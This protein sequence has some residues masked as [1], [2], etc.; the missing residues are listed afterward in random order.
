MKKM[1]FALVKVGSGNLSALLLGAISMKVLAVVTGPSGIGL[2]SL[3]KNLQQTLS[4]IGSL[5]GHNVIV[6][7]IPGQQKLHQERF[8]TTVFWISIGGALLTS[9]AAII[10]AEALSM[11]LLNAINAILMWWLVVP[12]SMG[13][14]FFYFRSILNAHS[15]VGSVAWVNASVGIAAALVAAP[16]AYAY[17]N[18]GA[19]ALVFLLAFPLAVGVA[20]AGS[21]AH[22]LGLF[23]YRKLFEF[24]LFDLGFAIQF[25]RSALPNLL[26]ALI[27][28]A[29]VLYIRSMVAR[30]YGLGGVG[31]F[32]AG[33]VVSTIYLALFLSAMQTYLLPALSAESDAILLRELFDNALRLTNLVVV[34]L[35]S[36]MIV[37]KPLFVKLLYSSDFAPAIKLLQ[38]TLIGDY[39]RVLGWVLATYLL[40]RLDMLAYLIHEI[41]WNL[42]FFTLSVWF[43]NV[44]L[45]GIG[46]AYLAAYAVHFASLMWRIWQRHGVRLA[47]SVVLAWVAGAGIILLAGLLTWDAEKID[48]KAGVI[49]IV[50]L[51]FSWFV[52]KPGERFCLKKFLLRW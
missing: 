37:G 50:A 22:G 49:M 40:A 10:F 15:E 45:S 24:R 32:D 17:E 18:Y 21:L 26:A 28:M 41:L 9:A 19:E 4:T 46:I 8:T 3:L 14:I 13:V 27:G 25:A 38:W 35:I 7:V 31:Y 1:V 42:V 51:M 34:P 16:V 52:M 36:L 43:L 5:G 30:E 11:H 29:T 44:G 6:Q 20:L 47:W 2:F 48:W 23:A 39:L 12:T 33:W